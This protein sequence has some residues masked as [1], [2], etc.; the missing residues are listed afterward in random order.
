MRI[1]YF[2]GFH[3]SGSKNATNSKH[4]LNEIPRIYDLSKTFSAC[5]GHKNE[6]K[7]SQENWEGDIVRI[8][9]FRICTQIELHII[10][11][12]VLSCCNH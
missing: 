9:G 7:E 3:L 8:L 12:H 4:F 5:N 2:K 6:Q 11:I 1:Q 10:R